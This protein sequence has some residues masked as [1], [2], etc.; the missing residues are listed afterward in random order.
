VLTPR[1]E[2]LLERVVDGYLD[3]SRPVASKSLAGELEWGSSTIRHELALLEE[4]GLLA[5]P[6]TSA[7]RVPT[8]SGYRYFVDRLLP[9]LREERSP[10]RLPLSLVQ[11]EVDEAMRATSETLSQVTSLL[12][13]V[14]AP[15]LETATIRHVEVLVLQPQVL[16]VVIITSTGGVT[17]RVFGF[18]EPVDTGLVVWAAAYLNEQL[19]G[20][21]LGAR[22]LAKRLAEPELG[23]SE[24]GFLSELAPAFIELEDTAGQTLY[25][26]GA[27]RLF[28]E[29]RLADI[30]QLNALMELLERRVTLLGVLRDA[31]GM[32]ETYIRIGHE[33]AAPGLQ[34]LAVVAQSYGLPARSLG[35]VSVI[36]PVRMDYER[37]IRS[38]RA[39]AGELSDF[40]EDVY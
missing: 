10:E 5:H 36:G 6:H 32:S 17:K 39:A 21:G 19:V 9:R 22:V 33:N 40:V 16:M 38:V 1:Q 7:G 24:R 37:A 2:L 27:T 15:P 34:S 13:I 30:S 29:H 28:A 14:T 11:R 4:Q 18:D 20:L 26:D 23:T 31:L 25:V 12:A 3:T 8:D 35:A